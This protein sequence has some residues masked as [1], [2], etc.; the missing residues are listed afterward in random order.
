MNYKVVKIIDDMNIVI[1]CGTNQSIKEGDLFYILSDLKE[2]VTDPDTNEVLGEF[3][4]IK[5]KIEAITVFE[6]MSICQNASKAAPIVDLVRSS[7][8]TEHRLG[9]NV[10]PEQIS[11]GL[12]DANDELIQ[13]GDTVQLV[14]PKF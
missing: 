7:F 2:K 3:N 1:N 10:D 9:L 14:V 6:K 8:G 12:F 11:G 13:I 4:R 5:A